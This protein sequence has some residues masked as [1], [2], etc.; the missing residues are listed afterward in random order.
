MCEIF[1]YSFLHFF[2]TS[3]FVC[4]HYILVCLNTIINFSINLFTDDIY[5]IDVRLTSKIV[6]YYFL[7]IFLN[8]V[9]HPLIT[10]IFPYLYGIVLKQLRIFFFFFNFH[11]FLSSYRISVFYL[12]FFFLSLFMLC[13][14]CRS[15][16]VFDL[17]FF[18]SSFNDVV[19]EY[20]LFNAVFQCD[21]RPFVKFYCLV[22][23][24]SYFQ[25]QQQQENKLSVIYYIMRFCSCRS[26]YCYTKL[27]KI[28]EWKSKR[29]KCSD[30]W[31]S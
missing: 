31:S 14:L 20:R 13:F 4:H 25:Q 7:F 2:F 24:R 6:F 19:W 3:K 16:L 18:F 29:F 1:W 21:M 28:H 12:N 10:I 11:S 26:V 30:L 27:R 17:E 8:K 22:L 5:R 23:S 9:D 15:F